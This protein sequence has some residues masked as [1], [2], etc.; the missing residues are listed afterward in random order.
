MKSNAQVVVIGGGVVGCSVLYHLAKLGW[1]DI[2]LVERK[3]LTAGSTWHAAGGFLALNSNPNIAKLQAY[4]VK[5]YP[6]IEAASGQNAGLHMTGG[7]NIAATPERWEYLKSEWARHR[8]MG[9]ESELVTPE[10]IKRLCPLVDTRGVLGGLYDPNEGHLDP[11]GTTH[12]YARAARKLGAKIYLQTWVTALRPQSTGA[13]DVVTDQGVIH[14]EHVVNAAGLWAREVGAMAG[15]KLPLHPMEHHYLITESIPELEALDTEIAMI[16]DL[17]GEMYFRQEHKGVLLGV[18]E[19]NVTPWAVQGTPWDYG[20]SDLLPPELER[21]EDALMKGFKRFPAVAEAGIKRIVNGPFTFTPDGNPLVGPVRGLRNFWCACGVMAGFS[22]G[23]GVGLAL[24]QWMIHGEPEGD[25]F[26]MDVARFGDYAGKTYTLAKASEFYARRFQ[27]AY[28]NE[29]WPAG[30]PCKKSAIFNELAKANAVFGVSYGQEIPLWFAPTGEPAAE[31]PT[32]YR[33]NA[34]PSVAAECEA[35]RTFV[36]IVDASSFAKYEISGAGAAEWLDRLLAC[37]LPQP[38]RIKLAPVLSEAGKLYGDLT[39]L[40]VAEDRFFLMGSGYLQNWHMRWFERHLP[41]RGVGVVNRS[42]ELQGLAIAGPQS[43]ALLKRLIGDDLDNASLPFLRV[44]ETE[45]GFAPAIL[46]RLSVTGEL[47]YE[48][49]V[50]AQYLST[51]YDALLA[52]GQDLGLK[53]FGMYAMNSLRLEKGFGIWSREFSPDYTPAMAGMDRF[54]AYDKPAFIGRDAALRERDRGPSQRLVSVEI[55]ADR[56]DA[57][58]YEPVWRDGELVGFVTSGGYGH[59]VKKS[60]AMA[61]IN[62]DA[63]DPGAGYRITVLAQDR[64]AR[65]LPAPAYDPQGE[66]LR[67]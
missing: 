59:T 3:Q 58:G 48:I 56:A 20:E 62:T 8:V 32:F 9:L 61:Y 33:S 64:R 18:Y 28:P 6:E 51:L 34:F 23:G 50:P 5:L 54:I 27:M 39:L 66:R 43:R 15:V 16:V 30:R 67:A 42:D 19:K 55:E 53:P 45:V 25:I 17:D 26:A 11:Y 37:R 44:T 65:L 52:A 36:G 2:V 38:S 14:A 63:I 46:A 1:T 10:E 60:L 12:A 4:T 21:L 41:A 31:T 49:Y 47:G 40:R 57:W 24:A 7:V 13:W 22:Q 35:V 29:F